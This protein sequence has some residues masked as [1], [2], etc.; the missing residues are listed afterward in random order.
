MLKKVLSIT[1]ALAMLVAALPVFAETA[2]MN[3]VKEIVP[4]GEADAYHRPMLTREPGNVA[5]GVTIPTS[6]FDGGVEKAN[7]YI[8]SYSN[9]TL[10]AVAV[11]EITSADAGQAVYTPSIA[12]DES[13][14]V[15]AFIWNGFDVIPLS[16]AA[17][18]PAK[19]T[20]V[21][22]DFE[23]D[24]HV[25]GQMPARELAAGTYR[26]YM[27]DFSDNVTVQND[28]LGENGKVLK[29]DGSTKTAGANFCEGGAL[30]STINKFKNQTSSSVEF[31]F[32]MPE[33]LPPRENGVDENSNPVY[34]NRE[35][36]FRVDFDATMFI[37]IQI[38][39]YANNSSSNRFVICNNKYATDWGSNKYV[40]ADD[41][42]GK[43]HTM[44]LEYAPC[45]DNPNA[46]QYWFWFDGELFYH[47]VGAE[48]G[49]TDYSY[50]PRTAYIYN[51]TPAGHFD[52]NMVYYIDNVKF[53]A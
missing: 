4:N 19:T 21:T 51:Y 43:W 34:A 8:A 2:E 47:V 44:K 32:Y 1:L 23:E 33:Q 14:E 16:T 38:R 39:Q 11:K 31:D 17:A 18:L 40:A 35:T 52:P 45:A 49:K 5:A 24:I 13:D 7:L 26:E 3:I 50:V 46:R 20:H 6:V 37:Y 48:T 42:F 25:V 28:P 12:V 27:K 36:Y 10:K 30:G 53:S 41:F 29:F 22:Y 15:K 9:S